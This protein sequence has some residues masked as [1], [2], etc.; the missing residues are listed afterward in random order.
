MSEDLKILAKLVDYP[1]TVAAFVW[2]LRM[3]QNMHQEYVVLLNRCLEEQ[4]ED[5]G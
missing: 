1:V 4:Y 2:A 3:I 5:D